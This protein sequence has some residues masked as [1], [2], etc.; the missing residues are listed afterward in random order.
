MDGMQKAKQCG[1]RSGPKK[2]LTPEQIIKLQ[3][4][5]DQGTLIKTLMH[6]YSLSKASV[7]RSV[8]PLRLCQQER[9]TPY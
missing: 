3:Q 4:R 1:V 6:D 2:K 5:R 7:Y 8:Q 9:L